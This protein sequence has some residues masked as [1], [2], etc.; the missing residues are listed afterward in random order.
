V[1]AIL[2]T[3]APASNSDFILFLV[4]ISEWNSSQIDWKHSHMIVTIALTSA[5]D[6]LAIGIFAVIPIT[7]LGLH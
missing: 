1:I 2:P 5:D 6:R 3:G 4:K 7:L